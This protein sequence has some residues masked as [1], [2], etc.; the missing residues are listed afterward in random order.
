LRVDFVS[1]EQLEIEGMGQLR[2]KTSPELVSGIGWRL[3][4]PGSCTPRRRGMQTILGRSASGGSLGRT[5]MF[6]VDLDTGVPG[7]HVSAKSGLP[8]FNVGGGSA[9]GRGSSRAF[10]PPDH[11]LSPYG[12]GCDCPRAEMIVAILRQT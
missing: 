9:M 3:T 5:A 12:L 2:T 8:G 4:A 1:H 11:L 6:N 10:D 7:F